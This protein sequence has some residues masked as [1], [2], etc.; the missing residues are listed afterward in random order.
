MDLLLKFLK[1]SALVALI[2]VLV[3]LFAPTLKGPFVIIH[4]TTALR[5]WLFAQV[6]LVGLFLAA[7]LLFAMSV[8]SGALPH[9]SQVPLSQRFA[10]TLEPL[11]C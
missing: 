3:V 2:F 9:C 7:R 11:R 4:F 8:L 5:G 6:V 10:A 1:I